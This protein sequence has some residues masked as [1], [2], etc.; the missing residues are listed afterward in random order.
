MTENI[1][2]NNIV[3]LYHRGPRLVADRETQTI[4]PCSLY[5]HVVFADKL[6]EIR[7]R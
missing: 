7:G 2:T 4:E 3:S 5:S 1:A 6:A